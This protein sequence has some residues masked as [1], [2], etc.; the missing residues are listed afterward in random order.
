MYSELIPDI[1]ITASSWLSS[2]H[3]PY[4]GRLG[5]NIGHGGWCAAASDANPFLEID[6][7][8]EHLINEIVT[9]GKHRLSSDHI[10][11]AWVTEFLIAFTT[12]RELWNNV[13]DVNTQQ[14]I[15]SNTTF[16]ISLFLITD[17]T[18]FIRDLRTPDKSSMLL[19]TVWT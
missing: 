16:F 7:G 2:L 17:I 18:V 8:M 10:G 11:E 19:Y 4:Y 3:L 9:E 1:H 5:R 6:L 13:T 14:P 12:T 15:V